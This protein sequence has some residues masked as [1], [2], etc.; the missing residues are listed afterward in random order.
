MDRINRIRN[1]E[2]EMLWDESNAIDSMTS[3]L[4]SHPVYPV[5]PCLNLT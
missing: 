1:D 2:E 4:V 5:H 3:I